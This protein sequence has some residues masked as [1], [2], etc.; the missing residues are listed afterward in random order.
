MT[1][2]CIFIAVIAIS[3]M[4]LFA[5]HSNKKIQEKWGKTG[6]ISYFTDAFVV[7]INTTFISCLV[8]CIFGFRNK[9]FLLAELLQLIVIGVL[10]SSSSGEGIISRRV[11]MAELMPRDTLLE[12][13][14]RDYLNRLSKQNE[15]PLYSR[16]TIE[17][18]SANTQYLISISP[19]YFV[20]STGP[21][22]KFE[23]KPAWLSTIQPGAFSPASVYTRNAA[24]LSVWLMSLVLRIPAGVIFL[25]DTLIKAVYGLIAAIGQTYDDSP[26]E[27][28][29]LGFQ[30]AGK[31]ICLYERMD[32]LI[33]KIISFFVEKIV[34]FIP[35]S[36]AKSIP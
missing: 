22:E 15:I 29:V 24:F 12:Q 1:M 4:I 21:E 36:E 33:R 26:A 27:S 25:A 20:V 34:R 5:C 11:L 35:F 28:F 19:D 32:H 7:L 14:C 3:A 23:Q 8:C 6:L 17:Y 16:P 2:M 10:F 31:V 9:A 13:T 18:A 30:A